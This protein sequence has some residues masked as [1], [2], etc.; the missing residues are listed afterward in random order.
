MFAFEGKTKSRLL[1]FTIILEG[2]EIVEEGVRVALGFALRCICPAMPDFAP[3]TFLDSVVSVLELLSARPR[4][5]IELFARFLAEDDSVAV[6]RVTAW[7]SMPV[8]ALELPDCSCGW[9]ETVDRCAL[10]PT[11]A[12]VTTCGMVDV[13]TPSSSFCL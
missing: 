5:L 7:A 13:H 8:A 4:S 1:P 2:L 11:V 9:V 12:S 3:P 10:D 6:V